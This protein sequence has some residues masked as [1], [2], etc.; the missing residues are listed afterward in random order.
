MKKFILLAVVL[1]MTC[2]E[3]FG[4]KLSDGL[5]CSSD[6]AQKIFDS[7]LVDNDATGVEFS[8]LLVQFNNL[9]KGCVGRCVGK[10]KEW[11]KLL[12]GAYTFFHGLNEVANY[13]EKNFVK[14]GEPFIHKIDKSKMVVFNLVKAIRDQCPVGVKDFIPVIKEKSP[15]EKYR[16]RRKPGRH[17][18]VPMPVC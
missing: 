17:K 15:T 7:A 13:I 12:T 5:S 8:S 6:H 16:P 18:K 2:A 10:D 9:S 1:I 14:G 3:G 11:K 4:V